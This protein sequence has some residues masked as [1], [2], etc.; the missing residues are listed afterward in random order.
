[1]SEKTAHL[2]L[3]P[4]QAHVL[5]A[6]VRATKNVITDFSQRLGGFE[7]ERDLTT[8]EIGSLEEIL[9]KQLEEQL[10]EE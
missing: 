1:M 8:A 9:V 2:N 7:L 10:P 4:H 3:T 6:C 5:L